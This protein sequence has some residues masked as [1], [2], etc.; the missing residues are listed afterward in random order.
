MIKYIKANSKIITK[1]IL[2]Q[3]GA[4][5]LGITLTSAA[6]QSNTLF[7]GLSVVATLFYMILLYNAIWEEGGKERIKIDGG[8]A[9]MK[10]LRGLWVSLIA[11]IP[12]FVLFFLIFIGRTFG[13]K[14]GFGYAWAGTCYS[15]GHGIAIFYEGMYAGLVSTFSPFNP[16]G[17]LLIILPAV[18]VCTVGYIICVNNIS[19]LGILTGKNRKKGKDLK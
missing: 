2:N 16:F 7:W 6:A 4:A 13:T 8:R 5:I 14:S 12:N 17:Y 1:L 19:I 11:N 18:F 15:I 3:V 9:E 10:P